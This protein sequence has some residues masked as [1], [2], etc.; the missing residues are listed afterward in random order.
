MKIIGACTPLS[1]FLIAAC[2]AYIPN[3]HRARRNDDWM[4]AELT[5]LRFPRVPSPDLAARDV[6]LG[7]L[8]SLQILRG[9]SS[10]QRVRPFLTAHCLATLTNR[11]PQDYENDPDQNLLQEHPVLSLFPQASRIRLHCD[12]AKCSPATTVR[13]DILSI[14]VTVHHSPESV[15]VH[16]P[17]GR[18]VRPVIG[19]SPKVSNVVV[20]M[21]QS[22]RPPHED[23]WM[24]REIANV[25][26][27]KGGQ[28]WSRDEGV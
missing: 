26:Y 3:P 28:G 16:S 5:V 27:A 15:F 8:R 18:F 11:N 19:S 7:C 23:C 6:A 9:G 21:E 4:E 14:P 13:G 20:R 17:S 25:D 1:I 22:R 2:S 10:L 24:V 12:R